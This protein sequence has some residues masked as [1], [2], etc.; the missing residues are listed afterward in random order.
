[1]QIVA[2]RFKMNAKIA[3]LSTQEEIN[4]K[5]TF[6]SPQEELIVTTDKAIVKL[7]QW[8]RNRIVHRQIKGKIVIRILCQ[9]LLFI[10]RW[11]FAT[12]GVLISIFKIERL[13]IR[14]LHFW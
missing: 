2:L 7:F 5:T 11:N 6:L 10:F 1:M 14:T 3:F 8:F 9:S 4:A 13:L 12:K